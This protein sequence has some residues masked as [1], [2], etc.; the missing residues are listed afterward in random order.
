MLFRSGKYSKEVAT[1]IEEK[2]LLT[3]SPEQISN[4]LFLG[5]LSFKTIYRWL[6]ANMLHRATIDQLRH[7]GKRQR[8]TETRGKFNIETT[9]SRRAKEVRKRE[10]F[11][12]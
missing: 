12:H 11:G 7:K 9:I 6:Y 5:T 2:L 4:R 1:L 8:P 3:W 10:S